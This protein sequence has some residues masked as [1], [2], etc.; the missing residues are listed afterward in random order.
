VANRKIA[1]SRR[2]GQ[3]A[4]TL[5]LAAAPSIG[6]SLTIAPGEVW[7]DNR[8]QHI[9]AHGGGILRYRDTYYWFGEERAQGL[10]RSKRY[11][12]CY[13]SPDL[14][15]WTFRN[16]VLKLSDP[17]NFGPS[18][19]LERPKVF[20]NSRTGKFVMY[21]HI[22]GP[23]PGETG[24]SYKLAR[25]G[26]ATSDTP[27]GDYTYLRSFRPLGHES[28]DIGQFVDDD[29]TPYLIFEDRPYGFRIA[30]LSS[31]YLSVDRE[32]C[33]IPLH[34]EG[35]AVVHY[36]GLYY[37]IGSALTGWSP[38]PNK[39]ATAPSLAGPWSEF[40][41]IAPP[42]TKTYGAQSTMMLKVVGDQATTV[43][44]M[45]DIWKPRTQWDS[46][47]LWMP[48]EIGGGKLWLPEPRPWTL[49]VKSGRAVIA[50]A[51]AE[52]DRAP[53][54]RL[55]MNRRVLWLG[56]SITQDGKYISFVE[57]YLDKRFPAENFDFVGIGL[58]SETVSGLSEKS[59][60]FPRPCLS[61]R[62]ARALDS[63]KPA[64]VIACYG[65]NDGI[66]HPQ[67]PER[68]RAFQDG[69]ERLSAAVQSAKAQF[70]L[71]T[72]PPFDPLP[73]R[74]PLPAGAPDFGYQTPFA[75][76]DSVL[77]EYSRWERT[78]PANQVRLVVDLHTA[79]NQYLVR[80]RVAQPKFSFGADG[81]HPSAAGHLLM[82]QTILRS[83]GIEVGGNDVDAELVRIQAD[84]LFALVR[85][86]REK[87]SAGWLA[88]VGYTREKTVKLD[89]VADT[90]KA[91][92][93][94]LS[95]I[96][97]LRR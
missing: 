43:I 74:T 4:A 1:L 27:D 35:G 93:E 83:F 82:A 17:E 39:Y 58:S 26:V 48:L 14:V 95:K 60:P 8:G 12:S 47:Y 36:Q 21:M 63:V 15:N 37:A 20:Y 18:W 46:R 7:P 59:H 10:D 67:S 78:L 22:D 94:A 11:V 54:E 72:P 52:P 45:G 97:A 66:Y 51:P 6:A 19:I 57:Y 81:I 56:D 68:L 65:M 24:G 91:A 70:I 62:L 25:V 34:L 33:L 9:Q 64:T 23:L 31:D 5:L 2:I 44:F 13:S 32:V 85:E 84:P 38:N 16:D 50:A 41:D 69:I 29:G 55:L 76:Y 89:S 87:R 77:D 53:V 61:E 88:F 73:V 96:D 49:D 92:A 79:L 30:T 42:E 90:E 28:R 71:L 86:R 75:D 80:Q 40:R 3:A